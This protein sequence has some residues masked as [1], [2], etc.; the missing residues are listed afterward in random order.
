MKQII[1]NAM[2]TKNQVFSPEHLH[3]FTSF[4]IH[5]QFLFILR[6]TSWSSIPYC[7]AGCKQVG[8]MKMTATANVSLVN[9]SKID[10]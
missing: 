4:S 5:M 9:I 1:L 10:P 6:F 7:T 2:V 3:I 8:L